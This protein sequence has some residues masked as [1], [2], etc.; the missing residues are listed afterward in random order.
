MFNSKKHIKSSSASEYD[1]YLIDL[2]S[3]ACWSRDQLTCKPD[4]LPSATRFL[5]NGFGNTKAQL[6]E[7]SGLTEKTQK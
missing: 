7:L 2:Q 3:I 4:E 5:T 1:R 6:F